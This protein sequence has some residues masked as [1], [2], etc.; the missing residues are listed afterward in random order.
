MKEDALE[1]LITAYNELCPDQYDRDNLQTLIGRMRKGGKT[2][3]EIC[4]CIAGAIWS[5][6]EH[7]IW[8]SVHRRAF[9]YRDGY[10]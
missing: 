9:S 2:E 4:T 7:G 5:G 3:K 8:P 10:G 1:H 6:L